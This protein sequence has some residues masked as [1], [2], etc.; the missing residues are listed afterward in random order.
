MSI[1]NFDVDDPRVFVFDLEFLGDVKF[2]HETRIYSIA[3]VHGASGTFFSKI[4]DPCANSAQ[5]K[6]FNTYNG[7]RRVTKKWLKK[8][9]AVPLAV[10]LGEM[11]TFVAN[12]MPRG[13]SRIRR[14]TASNAFFVSSSPIF[15]AHACFRADLPV[16]KSALCRCKL[17]PLPLNWR[18]FDSLWFFRRV[19][20]ARTYQKFS[21]SDVAETLGVSISK[22][23]MHDAL[24]DAKLLHTCLRKFCRLYGSL[25]TWWQTP[26]TVVPGIG[27]VSESRLIQFQ[28]CS[29]ESLLSIVTM[30]S[31]HDFTSLKERNNVIRYLQ[32]VGVQQANSVVEYCFDI[33]RAVP[34]QN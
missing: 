1:D 12:C 16:L 17:F 10:A 26:L 22:G 13:G 11:Q 8:Q 3:A 32:S 15:V 27:A 33:L 24:P 28:I 14:N 4:V 31:K 34:L 2:P 5:L 18:F 21:L 25:Y 20:T 23:N 19:L 29:L 9:N 30:L 6:A 7:C